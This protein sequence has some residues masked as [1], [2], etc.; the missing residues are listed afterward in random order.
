MKF[1]ASRLHQDIVSVYGVMMVY[2]VP[3]Y[4]DYDV[5]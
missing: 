4:L 1:V 2:Q 3:G 5:L